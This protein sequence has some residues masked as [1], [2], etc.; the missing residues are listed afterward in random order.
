LTLRAHKG[1]YA[2]YCKGTGCDYS[3]RITY[4]DGSVIYRALKDGFRNWFTQ[5]AALPAVATDP[6][7]SASFM[8]WAINVPGDKA[9]S[10]VEM[11]DT[12]SV[13]LGFPTNPTVLLSRNG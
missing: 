13:W 10:K 1:K 11:L 2:W 12:P 9:I 6:L 4:S 8:T 3:L 7:N 5:T